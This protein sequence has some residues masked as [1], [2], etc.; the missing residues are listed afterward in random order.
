MS[1]LT[2]NNRPG[3]VE[4]PLP[5][6][7]QNKDAMKLFSLR[8]L[9]NAAAALSLLVSASSCIKVT[10]DSGDQAEHY[11]DFTS[12]VETKAPV[13]S[14]AEM[15]EFAVWAAYTA[16][17][18]EPEVPMKEVK[19]YRAAYND[20]W[21]Y[22]DLQMW[23]EGD[24]HF[25]AFYP[26]PSELRKTKPVLNEDALDVNFTAAHSGSQTGLEGLTINYYYGPN[27]SYDLMTAEADRSYP[28]DGGNAVQFTFSHLLSRVSIAVKA[29]GDNVSLG[30]LTFEG[31][32]VLGEYNTA[33]SGTDTWSLLTEVGALSNVPAGNFTADLTGVADPLPSNGTS[34][35]V[36][37]DLLLIPQTP[38]T[39]QVEVTYTIGADG[40]GAGASETKS[41]PL[42]ADPA[43]QPGRHYRYTLI[44]GTADVSL[45][46]DV[47]DWEPAEDNNITW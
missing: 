38:G 10:P 4:C 21:V 39:A 27:A 2:Y 34:V 33:A 1:Y 18:E 35:D 46:I 29:A 11:I 19:V 44:L 26:L 41:L 43:W 42:P 47:V 37:S 23:K 40:A 25:E 24:W 31:M 6:P 13:E 14:S 3:G 5:V 22:D 16:V 9:L 32:S 8:I 28:A 36:L 12:S 20:V 7:N 15:D 30:S 17:G 45:N